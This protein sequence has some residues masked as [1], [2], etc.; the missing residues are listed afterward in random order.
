MS[1]PALPTPAAVQRGA[2]ALGTALRLSTL[3]PREQEAVFAILRAL[4]AA[5]EAMSGPASD[6]ED[7]YAQCAG[8]LLSLIDTYRR[9]LAALGG[10]Q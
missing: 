7:S 10:A 9:A 6:A 1:H 3:L 8:I 4:N 2:A 5:N